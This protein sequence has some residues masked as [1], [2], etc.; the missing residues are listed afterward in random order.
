MRIEIRSPKSEV[1]RSDQARLTNSSRVTSSET[2]HSSFFI[3]SS[4]RSLAKADHSSFESG[5]ITFLYIALLAIMMILVM[6]ETSSLIRLRREVKLMEQQQ[7][8]RVNALPANPAQT[9]TNP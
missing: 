3:R 9:T 6:V 2:A 1:R 8:K 5:M 4:R 7:I